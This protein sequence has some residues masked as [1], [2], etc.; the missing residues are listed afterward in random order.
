MWLKEQKVDTIFGY[1]GEKGTLFMMPC[2]MKRITHILTAHEQEQPAC[3]GWICPGNRQAVSSATSG[4]SATN[5]VTGIATAYMDSVP[6]VVFT[7]QVASPLLGGILSRSRY[8]RYYTA[9]YQTQL[10]C[11]RG[12]KAARCYQDA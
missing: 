2:L 5:T 12:I 7:G 10:Y 6:M 8:Y 3:S 9:Y 11:K 1:P 4:P